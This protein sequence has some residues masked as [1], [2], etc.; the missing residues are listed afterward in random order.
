VTRPFMCGRFWRA[1]RGPAPYVGIERARR[2]CRQGLWG[3]RRR[4]VG[5]AILAAVCGDRGQ[6]GAAG[7]L[8]LEDGGAALV[9]GA[10]LLPPLRPRAPGARLRARRHG[11]HRRAAPM[12]SRT[13]ET[14]MRNRMLWLPPACNKLNSYTSSM[15]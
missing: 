5:A 6:P 3:L 11:I 4:Q 2:S 9:A 7:A 8:G 10:Q 14:R 1:R 13:R 12:A 15:T